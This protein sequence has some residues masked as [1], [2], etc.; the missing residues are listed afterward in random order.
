MTEHVCEKIVK[1]QDELEGRPMSKGNNQTCFI[2]QM[3]YASDGFVFIATNA[4]LHML[5]NPPGRP[6][7]INILFGNM[8][9]AIVKI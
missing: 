3:V 1:L 8:W 5:W 9:I 6:E 4:P 2:T 7:S